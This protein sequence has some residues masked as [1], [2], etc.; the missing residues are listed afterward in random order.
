MWELLGTC[1][2]NGIAE[3]FALQRDLEF[4]IRWEDE[5]YLDRIA[6]N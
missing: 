2:R 5:R 1:F 3:D 4:E 6:E